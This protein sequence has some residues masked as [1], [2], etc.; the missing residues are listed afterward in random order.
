MIALG[1][2]GLG[3]EVED[4]DHPRWQFDS[5][6]RFPHYGFDLYRRAH[7]PRQPRTLAVQVGADGSCPLGGLYRQ[8]DAVVVHQG[9]GAL[10]SARLWGRDIAEAGL[11]SGVGAV[12]VPEGVE[13]T[14]DAMDEIVLPPGATLQSIDAIPI[15]ATYFDP[16]SGG[17]HPSWGSP[18]NGSTRI[19]LP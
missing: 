16:R 19:L 7:V 14:A 9:D 18:L 11:S 12:G 15:D 17:I 10:V 8:V 13:L 5:E 1:A 4:G 2:E 3:S 6:L